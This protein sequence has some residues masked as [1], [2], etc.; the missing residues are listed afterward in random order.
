MGTICMQHPKGTEEDVGYCVA[1][2]TGGTARWVL[3]THP[4]YFGNNIC[5]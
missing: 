4:G 5:F 3:G 1:G 2:V